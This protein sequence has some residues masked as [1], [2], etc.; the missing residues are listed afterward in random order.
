[1][2]K[3]LLSGI[4]MLLTKI[5]LSQDQIYLN[6]NTKILARIVELNDYEIKY[7]KFKS[8][9]TLLY[10]LPIS[11]V[12][13]VQFE[14]GSYEVIPERPLTVTS[15]EE[16]EFKRDSV[17]YYRYNNTVSY[18]FF[19]FANSEISLQY[20]RDFYH[21]NLVFVLPLAV[22]VS[23]PQTVNKYS[24][25]SWFSFTKKKYEFGAG[26]YYYAASKKSHS[27]YVGPVFRFLEFQC[28]SNYTTNTGAQ[29]Y[30]D[31]NLIRMA[32]TIT[33]GFLIRTV[34]RLSLNM[35]LSWGYYRDQVIDPQIR[36]TD[37]SQVLP[38]SYPVNS[39]IWP[40]FNIGYSF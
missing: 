21:R 25:N 2:K 22:G 26:V 11:N 3:Y 5:C 19:G 40:G 12:S 18:N 39:T 29:V 37:N 36:P 32:G 30:K 31:V 1:M 13:L 38:F 9:D 4:L 27:F 15:L 6:N 24:G 23:T 34:N 33:T 35:F 8:S 7:Y 20:Q 17:L 16:Y 14:N 28:K 10:S